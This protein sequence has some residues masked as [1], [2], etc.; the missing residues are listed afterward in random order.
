MMDKV[1]IVGNFR[2]RWRMWRNLW[3]LLLVTLMMILRRT[4]SSGRL[5]S[6]LLYDYCYCI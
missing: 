6:K 3:R 5:W 4:S 1:I 2:K